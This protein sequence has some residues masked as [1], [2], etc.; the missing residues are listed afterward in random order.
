VNVN[1]PA[2]RFTWPGATAY[3]AARWALR[4]F[5]EALRSDLYRTALKVTHFV[6][7]ETETPY[8][9]TNEE[10]RE[11]LPKIAK[12]I[13]VLTSERAAQALVKGVERNAREVVVP[14]MM[15]Q[16]YIQHALAP[17]VVEWLMRTTGYR[18][19]A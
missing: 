18:R 7:G 6:A 17:R 10:S 13:P 16:V 12:L 5:T 1:S 14:F 3:T 9:E 15:K 2:S 19:A 4:G 8:W 11:R